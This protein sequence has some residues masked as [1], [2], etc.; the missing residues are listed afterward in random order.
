MPVL[1]E[2]RTAMAGVATCVALAAAEKLIAD[3]QAG[4]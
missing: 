1:E 4:R 2:V 3:R